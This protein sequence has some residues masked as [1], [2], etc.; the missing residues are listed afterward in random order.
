[1]TDQISTVTAIAQEMTATSEEITTSI[2]E[3]DGPVRVTGEDTDE[4]A[5]QIVKQVAS[6]QE[7][8]NNTGI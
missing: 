6:L 4:M 8:N 1:M 5:Q 2:H 3:V 7:I